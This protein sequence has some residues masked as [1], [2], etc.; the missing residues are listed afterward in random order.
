MSARG[1]KAGPTICLLAEADHNFEKSDDDGNNDDGD[2][3]NDSSCFLP[4][5][6][7][8]FLLLPL[9]Y[10]TNLTP[11]SSPS[12]SRVRA[13]SPLT[14]AFCKLTTFDLSGVTSA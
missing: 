1:N 3:K 7:F 4:H 11:C 13:S 9:A 6:S 2:D 12:A 14:M 8:V 10:Q 5:P